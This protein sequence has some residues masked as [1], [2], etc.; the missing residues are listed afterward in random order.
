MN[1]TNLLAGCLCLGAGIMYLFGMLAE[2]MQQE[3]NLHTINLYEL[4]GKE[5]TLWI[6]N[7]PS[8]IVTNGLDKI[9]NL[10]IY[11]LLLI[12]GGIVFIFNGIFRKN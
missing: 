7:L 3:S 10:Q 5:K 12:A 8:E 1:K 9:F 4:L 11:I 2:L 6:A